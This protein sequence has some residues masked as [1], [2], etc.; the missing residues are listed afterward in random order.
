M[1]F[2]GQQQ[3]T[4]ATTLTK[5]TARHDMSS[6]YHSLEW[7]TRVK[8]TTTPTT[9]PRCRDFKTLNAQSAN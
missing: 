9:G 1:T 7:Y 6:L 4:A 3:F 8:Y 2:L 5:A